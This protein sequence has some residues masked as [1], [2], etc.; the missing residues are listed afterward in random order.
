MAE[1]EL[2]LGDGTRDNPGRETEKGSSLGRQNS[3]SV[4]RSGSRAKG[5]KEGA[6]EPGQEAPSLWDALPSR[7]A[8]S[9][10]RG[11]GGSPNK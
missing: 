6:R 5:V 10:G 9:G 3:G 7:S 11:E 4:G 2:K 1:Q 8:V